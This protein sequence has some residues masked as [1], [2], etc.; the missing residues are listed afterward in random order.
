[1]VMTHYGYKNVTPMTINSN[2]S[3]FATYYPAYLR[4]AIHADGVTATRVRTSIDPTLAAG[5]PVIVGVHAYGG[6]HF[7]VL[8]SG[9]NGNYIMRDPYISN[10]KDVSFS[11]HYSVASIYEINKVVIS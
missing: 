2:P 7:V 9:S 5:D 3:N 8:V 6:T 11:A 1:M 4:Y 10:G